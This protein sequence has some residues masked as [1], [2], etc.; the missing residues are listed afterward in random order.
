MAKTSGRDKI[1][2]NL[3]KQDD[4]VRWYFSLLDELIDNITSSE[5]ALSYCFHLIEMAQ[6]NALYALLM[7]EYR[8]DA[9]LTWSAVQNRTVTR[10][11][12]SEL[13]EE[14]CGQK[15]DSKSRNIIEP[16]EIV[17]DAIMHGRNRKQAE[18]HESILKC[19][20]YVEFIN[21]EFAKK[22]GFRPVGQLKGVTGKKGKPQLDTKTTRAVLKGLGFPV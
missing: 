20:E 8:T 5:P 15:L 4:G 12:F 11:N 19:L 3:A 21:D 6:R 9:N 14:I 18:I 22:V 17:R 7:R 10:K 2:N 13:F 16:A 1:K